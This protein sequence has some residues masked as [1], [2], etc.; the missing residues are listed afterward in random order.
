MLSAPLTCSFPI[1]L[2][3]NLLK[4]QKVPVTYVVM[5]HLT[6]YLSSFDALYL[7]TFNFNLI[8]ASNLSYQSQYYLLFQ[9]N[10]CIIQDLKCWKMI[11]LA[12]QSKRLY[13]LNLQY[14]VLIPFPQ[15]LILVMFWLLLFLRF[16]TTD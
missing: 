14:S 7:P 13:F 1:Q 5:V 10:L 16:G 3:L 15:L 9:P 2:A 6:S 4:G 8:Y 11:G 12:R